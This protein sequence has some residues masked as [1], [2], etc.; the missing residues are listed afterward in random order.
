VVQAYEVLL[1]VD[2]VGVF[3]VPQYGHL[4][5]KPGGLHRPTLTSFCI[6]TANSFWSKQ[7]WASQTHAL[8]LYFTTLPSLYLWE[9]SC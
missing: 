1:E 4:L 5:P 9:K 3:E 7:R 6:L 8:L 2:E